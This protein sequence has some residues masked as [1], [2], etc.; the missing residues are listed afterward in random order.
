MLF[1]SFSRYSHLHDLSYSLPVCY[2][3]ATLYLLSFQKMKSEMLKN[4]KN[5]WFFCDLTAHFC[6]LEGK[7]DFQIRF[8]VRFARI[9][10][11]LVRL[12]SSTLDGFLF[13]S[14]WHDYFCWNLFWLWKHFTLT[15]FSCCIEDMNFSN[16]NGSIFHVCFAATSCNLFCF[17]F[18]DKRVT[19]AATFWKRIYLERWK[20]TVV[21]RLFSYFEFLGF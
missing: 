4:R 18:E 13:F 16:F 11:S 15:F 10:G 1:P 12:S 3:K 14:T 5:A 21:S 7:K 9:L 17:L 20:L 6:C 2:L 19:I 8:A